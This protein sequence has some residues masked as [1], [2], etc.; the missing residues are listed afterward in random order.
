MGSQ[1]VKHDWTT[2]N[3]HTCTLWPVKYEK[4]FAGDFWEHSSLVLWETLRNNSPFLLLDMNKGQLV[5]VTAKATLWAGG[6]PNLGCNW[7]WTSE[8]SR[9]KSFGS[10]YILSLMSGTLRLTLSSDFL[11]CKWIFSLIQSELVFSYWSLKHLKA[12]IFWHWK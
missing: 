9:G 7:L 10:S 12:D 4:C 1:R 6:K 11:L 2:E 3:T 5:L 8:E